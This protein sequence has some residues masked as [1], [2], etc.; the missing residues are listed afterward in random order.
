MT[1][2][3]GVFR[4]L[5]LALILLA[6]SA[7]RSGTTSSP[8]RTAGHCVKM[9][10]KTGL[11][12]AKTGVTTGVEGV[13]AVGKTVGGF[14]EGG[15]DEAKREWQEGKQETRRTA[16]SGADEVRHEADAPDCP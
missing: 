13:K 5:A 1:A 2:R 6:A 9:G 10:A 7:C 15:S 4:S 11:A 8:A 3:K 14:V 12:G 16:H